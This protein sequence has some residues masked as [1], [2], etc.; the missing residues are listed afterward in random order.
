MFWQDFYHV[1]H[2]GADDNYYEPPVNT[3]IFQD[4]DSAWK[5]AREL[6]EKIGYVECGF[7]T[8]DKD[9]QIEALSSEIYYLSNRLNNLIKRG[10]QFNQEQT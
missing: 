7:R 8:L 4:E 6:E 9:S 5:Y 3:E 1:W 2:G 10:A